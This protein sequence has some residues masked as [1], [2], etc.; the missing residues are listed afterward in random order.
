MGNRWVHSHWGCPIRSHSCTSVLDGSS[1]FG[2]TYGDPMGQFPLGMSHHPTPMGSH[3]W[4]SYGSITIGDVP[5][6]NPN[7]MSDT[8]ILWVPSNRGYPIRSH[9]FTPVLDGSSHFGVPY[10]DPMG[11]IPNGDTPSD[12]VISPRC[13]LGPPT[14]GSHMGTLWVHSQMGI[15]HQIPLF[16]SGVGWVLPLWGPIWGSYGSNPKWRYPIS[17]PQWD[18]TYGDPMGPLQ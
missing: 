12:P 9:S 4:G 14:L 15:S 6:P 8:G 7:G 5:S 1:H 10:G 3:I 17:P 18:L 16:Y 13:R 11:P 2:V